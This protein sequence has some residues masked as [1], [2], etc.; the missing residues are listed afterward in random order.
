M[1]LLQKVL[2]SAACIV[3][4]P[5]VHGGALAGLV[6]TTTRTFAED[7]VAVVDNILKEETLTRLRDFVLGSTVF[8]RA[9]GVRAIRAMP[10][11][12]V[13]SRPA[14]YNKSRRS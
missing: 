5:S 6:E 1:L 13:R 4:A 9:Y 10:R 7:G 8:T 14:S 12:L 11:R 2:G 3:D